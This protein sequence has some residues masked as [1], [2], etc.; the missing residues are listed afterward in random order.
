MAADSEDTQQRE[1]AILEEIIHFYMDK[2]EAISARTLSKI[3]RL[4]LSPTTIRNLM[5]DLSAEGFLTNEG[6]TRGRIPTQK[7][8]AIYVTR[9]DDQ[10][11]PPPAR[12]PEIPAM[13][14]G[15]PALMDTVLE[16][17]GSYL[18]EHTGCAASVVLPNR[19]RYPLNWARFAEIPGQQ[20]VMTLQTLFGDIWTKV[21]VAPGPFPEDILGEVGQFISDTYR[22]RTLEAV[23]NDIMAGE[24]QELLSGMPSLGTAFRMLRKA[25]EWREAPLL[26]VWGLDNLYRIPE[27]NDPERLAIVHQALYDTAFLPRVLSQARGVGGGWIA[28]GTENGIHGLESCALVGYPFGWGGW[29][30]LM[31]VFGPMRMDYGRVLAQTAQCAG[32]LNHHLAETIRRSGFRGRSAASA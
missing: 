21:L 15:H 6:V 14:E 1:L 13:E 17:I 2:H 24:P 10:H 7:A 31:A 11:Q 19:E 22:G 30:G 8:F 3:S 5:E 32:L 4:S 27:C 28:I 12:A 23:R 18:A 26:R 29:R 16:E 9:L 25:F 20:V